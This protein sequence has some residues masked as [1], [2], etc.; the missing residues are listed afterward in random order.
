MSG[1]YDSVIGVETEQVVQRFLTGMPAK[2]EPAK[3]NAKMCATLIGCDPAT[4]RADSIRH[5][6]LGE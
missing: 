4:G 3:G 6:M 2:F 5:M 1:P